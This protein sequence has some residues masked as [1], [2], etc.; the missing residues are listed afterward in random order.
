M[1]LL[2]QSEPNEHAQDDQAKRNGL[3]QALV[4]H[5]ATVNHGF[6]PFSW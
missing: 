3:P 1:F 6:P 2:V 4:G 5:V